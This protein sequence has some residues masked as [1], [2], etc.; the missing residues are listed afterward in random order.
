MRMEAVTA[1]VGMLMVAAAL[2][3]ADWRL[4]LAALGVALIASSVDARRVRP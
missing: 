1:A 2:A 3:A 4:G